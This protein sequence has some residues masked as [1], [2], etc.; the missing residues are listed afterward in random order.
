MASATR[1]VSDN[2]DGF[3]EEVGFRST[4]IRTLTGNLVSVPN[5]RI[6]SATLENVARR[7][8]LRWNT[9]LGL[10]C[11]TGPE[12]VERAVQI[13]EEILTDHEGM[14]SDYPPKVHFNG[15]KDWSLNLS[16]YAWYF[17][18]AQAGNLAGGTSGKLPQPGCPLPSAAGGNAGV[19]PPPAA[20]LQA[21]KPA[22]GPTA[23]A[24]D[25]WKFQGWVQKT[26]LEIMHAVSYRGNRNGLPDPGRLSG[27]REK[28]KNPGAAAT[29]TGPPPAQTLCRLRPHR[30]R[31]R[32][33][34]QLN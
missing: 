20:I 26:C 21:G 17:P 30:R 32:S 12:K 16:V 2:H 25:F 1:I 28:R 19:S 34:M 3:V 27:S 23:T 14:R 5:E 15:F 4:R 22:G 9:E 8:Y 24:P 6:I 18:P 7:S 10:T 33:Q 31:K 11:E 13:V 29:Q